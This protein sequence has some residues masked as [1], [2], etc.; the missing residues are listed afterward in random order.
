[1][2][3]VKLPASS[4]HGGQQLPCVEHSNSGGRRLR[5]HQAA[6]LRCC[7]PAGRAGGAAAGTQGGQGGVCRLSGAL[8]RGVA[9]F[10]EPGHLLLR[11]NARLENSQWG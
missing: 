10:K 5:F 2:S 4:L 3:P 8:G 11:G 9:G 1:M 7:S 6:H